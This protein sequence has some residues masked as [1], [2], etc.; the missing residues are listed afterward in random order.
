MDAVTAGAV[1]SGWAHRLGDVATLQK[2]PV[3]D[4]T[5][6]R[7]G[8]VVPNPFVPLSTVVE[9]IDRRFP[10]LGLLGG[11]GPAAPAEHEVRH[12][13][14]ADRRPVPE[15]QRRLNLPT[16]L[17]GL[18]VTEAGAE[19]AALISSETGILPAEGARILQ[20]PQLARLTATSLLG[21]VSC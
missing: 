3:A 14:H 16:S 2:R 7:A 19:E 21:S 6:V 17:D 12:L 13:R 1:G 15:R 4:V 10:V 5:F 20:G 18:V 8:A 9:R 11:H